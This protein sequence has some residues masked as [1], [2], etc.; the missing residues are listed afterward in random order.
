MGSVKDVTDV[1]GSGQKAHAS[2]FLVHDLFGVLI[3]SIFAAYYVW[4][5][6]TYLGHWH[7]RNE[8][9][10]NSTPNAI[11]V[12]WSWFVVGAVGLNL[13]NYSLAGFEAGMLASSAFQLQ[14][15]DQ[16][17]LH[18]D[19]S[20][21]LLSGWRIALKSIGG[22]ILKPGPKRTEPGRLWSILFG[23]SVL[24][25]SFV[26]SG[27]TMEVGEGYAAGNKA[28]AYVF[29]VN[30]STMNNR[31]FDDISGEATKMWQ[32][33]LEPQIPLAGALYT[34]PGNRLDTDIRN[35]PIF[36]SV[37]SPDLFLAPQAETPVI[38]EV[39]GLALKYNC[40]VVES[41]REFTILN[42]PN[43]L[44]R[45][46]P[47]DPLRGDV[48]EDGEVYILAQGSVAGSWGINLKGIAQ[49]GR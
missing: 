31:L 37:A 27:L 44:K 34:S 35:L 40:T 21:S 33:G 25:W 1:I 23:L 46:S 30:A 24:S 17:M 38:G 29:G 18:G 10:A 47:G 36:P 2:R 26:L 39:W 48:F 5:Y 13:S 49:M 11:Y 16:A 22:R 43:D 15:V 19:K 9:V 14:S 20:W 42:R 12:W 41:M 7:S 45:P 4:I 3:P 32:Y 8:H 6:V 28:G